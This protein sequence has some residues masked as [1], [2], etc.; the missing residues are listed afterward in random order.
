MRKNISDTVRIIT[1][2]KMGDHIDQGMS[3]EAS[4]LYVVF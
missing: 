3:N 1:D 2:K 4:V